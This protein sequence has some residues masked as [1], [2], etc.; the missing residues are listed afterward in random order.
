M[1]K[2]QN[3]RFLYLLYGD[4]PSCFVRALVYKDEF[5]KRGIHVDY[6]RL[7]SKFLW[8][9][10][11]YFSFFKPAVLLIRT[12]EKLYFIKRQYSLLKIVFKYD[13]IIA[14]KYID[15]KLL[16]Q[17][18]L[19]GNACLIYDF[20][21][22]VWL[23]SFYGEEE[24]SKKVTAVE[25]VTSDNSYLAKVAFKYNKNSFIVNGPCQI[26]KFI[27]KS[28]DLNSTTNQNNTV[29]IGWIGSPTSIFYLYKIYDALEIIG[30]KYSNVIL[31]LVGTGKEQSL[32]PPF[33]KIKVI[34]IPTY[35]QNEMI[36]QVYS[37]DIGLYPLFLNELSLGRG[38]LKAT[39]Y[40]SGSIPLVCSAIGENLNIIQDG[41]NGFLAVDTKDW[42]EKLSRLIENP[43]L[44]KT[45][46]ENGFKFAE[47]NYSIKNCLNQFLKIV[48]LNN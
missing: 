34:N 4:G 18:K 16:N 35:D 15:S 1:L 10:I 47:A 24:F 23:D 41:I 14:V 29:I 12:L 21:D 5:D 37:F 45:I 36:N 38:S 2:L 11:K 28:K 32:I 7:N 9:S 6:Y 42:I 44:R 33:E 3:K 30:E 39:I 19:K 22:A 43:N 13:I 46:G 48:E 25:Y 20:D 40:M 17:I 27:C 31:K 8:N 26:E